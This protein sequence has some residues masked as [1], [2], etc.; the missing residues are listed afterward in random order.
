MNK[1]AEFPDLAAVRGMLQRVGTREPDAPAP[2]LL[3]VPVADD[4]ALTAVVAELAAQGIP[5]S[6][7]SLRLPSLDEVFYSL[8]GHTEEKEVA[9]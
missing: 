4:S 6:E 2:D 8:T 5:V 1:L 9:A 3:S 7:L